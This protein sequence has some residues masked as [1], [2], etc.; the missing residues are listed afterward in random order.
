M[1]KGY[2]MPSGGGRNN[3]MSQIGKLQEQMAKA[4]QELAAEI[5][6]ESSGGGAVAVSL[7]GEKKCLEVKIDPQLLAD[8]DVELLQD[9]VMTAFNK[10][11]EAVNARSD[12]KMGPFTG[13]LSGFGLG[14]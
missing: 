2:T 8:G 12:E 13:M 1:A 6:T 9:M 10:A 7:N 4:Q 3:M 11:L 14:R 5:I